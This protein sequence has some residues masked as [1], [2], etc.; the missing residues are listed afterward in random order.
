MSPPSEET[1]MNSPAFLARKWGKKA[2]DLVAAFVAS[3]ETNHT[4]PPPASK[5]ADGDLTAD[6][7]GARRDRSRRVRV[8]YGATREH[9]VDRLKTVQNLS[10]GTING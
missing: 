3:H 4:P 1:L 9:D 6:V 5:I 7:E 8:H 2:R 10:R